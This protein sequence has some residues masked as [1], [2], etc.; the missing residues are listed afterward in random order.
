M[1][2]DFQTS[3]PNRLSLH[4]VTSKLLLDA[5]CRRHSVAAGSGSGHRLHESSETRVVRTL[6]QLARACTQISMETKRKPHPPGSSH[7]PQRLPLPVPPRSATRA[8]CAAPRPS[9]GPS[10]L[11]ESAQSPHHTVIPP[12]SHTAAHCEA[13][14]PVVRS[15]GGSSLGTSS[16]SLITVLRRQHERYEFH[17]GSAA[18]ANDMVRPF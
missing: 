2:F 17:E 4:C 6:R 5:N 16:T 10:K 7:R 13:T 9:L 18:W 15:A 11:G 1:A 3:S 8:C 14:P 12:L